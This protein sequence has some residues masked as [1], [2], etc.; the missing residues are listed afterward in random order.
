M[1]R[2]VNNA[3]DGWSE[4]G[5][6]HLLNPTDPDSEDR[7]WIGEVW[8]NLIDA[9]LGHSVRRP[10][11]YDRPALT[12]ISVSSP[13]T[14]RPFDGLN[15]GKIYA[16]RVKPFNF[17]LSAHL[18]P[19]G[20]PT[21][22]DPHHFH[23]VAPY[24]SDP[25]KWESLKWIDR[26]S[27]R[28]CIAST[29]VTRGAVDMARLSTYGDLLEAYAFHPEAKSADASGARCVKQT[30]GLLRRRHISI[31]ALHHVGKEANRLE[32]VATCVIQSVDE[33]MLQYGDPSR[34]VWKSDVLDGIKSFGLRSIARKTRLSR[35]T[36][37]RIINQN[38]R[39]RKSTIEA[40]QNGL[41]SLQRSHDVS[42]DHNSKAPLRRFRA[43]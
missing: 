14:L 25:R 13:T 42:A 31:A 12:R 11:W 29:L 39:P 40:L 19:D 30:I 43:V 17:L 4:H 20:H 5:L 32:D 27:G 34:D 6:G 24:E 33:V 36:I 41:E 21:G 7:A 3:S 22:V 10:P 1:R 16:N 9:A 26:Y 2:G 28:R 23:L 38:T 15:R 18:A 8:Q 37:Q 35:S